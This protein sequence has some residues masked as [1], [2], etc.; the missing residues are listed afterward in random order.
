MPGPV[1]CG[2]T[3][4]R[5]TGSTLGRLFFGF[6]LDMQNRVSI[7]AL[8]NECWEVVPLLCWAY[9]QGSALL[10]SVRQMPATGMEWLA[11]H[12]APDGVRQSE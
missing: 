8:G 11:I 5:L 6:V 9:V 2:R 12:L 10:C 7:V 3:C 4:E 1:A